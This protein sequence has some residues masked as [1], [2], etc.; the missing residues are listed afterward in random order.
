MQKG[1]CLWIVQAWTAMTT[2]CKLNHFWDS[3]QDVFGPAPGVPPGQFGFSSIDLSWCFGSFKGRSL[4]GMVLDFLR[5]GAVLRLLQ[6]SSFLS[7]GKLTLEGDE[8]LI[9]LLSAPHLA[10]SAGLCWGKVER[11]HSNGHLL[12]PLQSFVTLVQ[13][14]IYII[15]ALNI[16]WH[17]ALNWM[18]FFY[19]VFPIMGLI[20]DFSSMNLSSISFFMFYGISTQQLWLRVNMWSAF[21]LNM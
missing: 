18:S 2:F 12:C 5:S 16:Y 21:L 10:P 9:L 4:Q 6:S 13:V 8:N 15:H 11:S 3:S 1:F 14:T 20:H 19:S 7:G 17:T